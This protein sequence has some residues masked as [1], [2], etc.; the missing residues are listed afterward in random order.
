MGIMVFAV[1]VN[2][3]KLIIHS[4]GEEEIKQIFFLNKVECFIPAS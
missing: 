1:V 3:A 4:L 2:F